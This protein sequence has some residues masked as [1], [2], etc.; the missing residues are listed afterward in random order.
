MTHRV[1]PK[2]KDLS[3]DDRPREKLL[4]K[5]EKELSDSEL[6]AI[7]LNS[8]TREKSVIQ[9]AQELLIKANHNLNVLSGFTLHEI[10]QVKGIGKARAVILK[11]ALE[12]GNR[13]SAEPELKY[14][15]VSSSASAFEVL[16]SKFFDLKEEKFFIIFLN[17]ANKI[18]EILHHTTGGAHG[19]VVDIKWIM[20]KVV[21]Y[22]A[23][24]IILAHNHP[25]GNVQPSKTDIELTENIKSAI[26]YFDAKLLDHII[27]HQHTYY[28]FADNGKI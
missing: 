5:G 14:V 8:G 26:I 19:T 13:R 7:L 21:Q 12:L 22:R 16:K 18:L 17:R 20:Q 9:L 15:T 27:V 4:K 10:M 24:S 2:V 3:P 1:F 11:A 6:I 23:S 25:S 28:S